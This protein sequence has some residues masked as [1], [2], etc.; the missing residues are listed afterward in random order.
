MSGTGWREKVEGR[1]FGRVACEEVDSV[2]E[3]GGAKGLGRRRAL[4]GAKMC[5]G[6]I[7]ADG[8]MVVGVFERGQSRGQ[9]R[10]EGGGR[11]LMRSECLSV[12]P[13]VRPSV[14]R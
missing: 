1:G 14:C 3:W 6:D 10:G 5:G 2:E 12:R 11:R 4:V 13:S 7:G 9:W 8:R